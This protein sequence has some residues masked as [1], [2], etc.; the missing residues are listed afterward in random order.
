[1]LILE[2]VDSSETDSENLREMWAAKKLMISHDK[3]NRRVIKRPE[4]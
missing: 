1:M 2:E 4:L 3:P